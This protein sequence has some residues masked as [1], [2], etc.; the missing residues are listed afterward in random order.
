MENPLVDNNSTLKKMLQSCIEQLKEYS[1]N[2][3]VIGV[4]D[5]FSISEI[6]VFIKNISTPEDNEVLF[7]ELNHKVKSLFN[8]YL[9]ETDIKSLRWVCSHQLFYY[10]MK[11]N[12]D[13]VDF[14]FEDNLTAFKFYEEYGIKACE[15]FDIEQRKI[16]GY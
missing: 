16:L 8:N 14:N 13:T 4:N 11:D 15:E 10:F 9:K 2:E 3:Y 6:E 7:A 12:F 5:Q 1:T